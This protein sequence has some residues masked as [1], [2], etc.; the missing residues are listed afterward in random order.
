MRRPWTPLDEEEPLVMADDV[1]A[2]D[3]EASEYPRKRSSYFAI[4]VDRYADSL[5]LAPVVTKSIT[6]ALIFAAS[7]AF[8]ACIE[9]HSLSVVWR[10]VVASAL[11]G[12]CFFG[13]AAHLWYGA[14]Q[15]T[16]PS[17]S[18]CTVIIK[19]ALGQIVFAPVFT[20]VF[21]GASLVA[22]GGVSRLAYLPAK[23]SRDLWPTMRT[24]LIFWPIVDLGSYVVIARRK[25]GEDWIPP[26]AN[27]CSFFWQVYLSTVALQSQR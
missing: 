11:V 4:L 15:R 22:A 26:F 5:H 3:D 23:L 21:F 16:F 13:P 12:L 7:D 14:M 6:S 2:A 27:V 25:G 17:S 10:Q 1:K 19:V 9:R 24:G 18:C 8:A 20:I